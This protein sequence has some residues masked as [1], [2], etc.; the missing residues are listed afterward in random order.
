M[1]SERPQQNTSKDTDNWLYYSRREK[2]VAPVY[3]MQAY[4]QA[5][6]KILGQISKLIYIKTQEKII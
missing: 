4:E 3:A 2:N 5:A 1:T 6:S